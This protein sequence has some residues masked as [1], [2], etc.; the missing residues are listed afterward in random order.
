MADT[1]LP[2]T[3]AD[4]NVQTVL[5][6]AVEDLAAP[7]VSEA[8]A[9]TA[10]DISC[11]LTAGGFAL[12]ID[13]A[14]ISDERECDTIVRQAPG[15]SS[16]SLELT[17]IDNTNSTNVDALNEA[18]EALT[19][20]SSWVVLRRR[21]LPHTQVLAADDQLSFAGRLTIGKRREVQSEANSVLRSTVSAFVGE[22]T[23]DAVVV[24]DA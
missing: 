10:V 6:P 15:R 17:V 3:P 8:T 22:F 18:L 13:Q 1:N 12:T 20:G 16:A 24:A 14:T 21:G 9:V 23:S 11:Y 2:S 5:V 4:G 19:E 7:T